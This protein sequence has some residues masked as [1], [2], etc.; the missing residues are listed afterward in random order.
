ML[1]VL[2]QGARAATPFLLNAAANLGRKLISSATNSSGSSS[3]LA[4]LGKR[5]AVLGKR[6]AVLGKRADVLVG[7]PERVDRLETTVQSL[8]RPHP[9]D[10]MDS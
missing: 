2:A 3:R 9:T 4:N 1:S 8:K 6:A 10:T 7:L 5:A